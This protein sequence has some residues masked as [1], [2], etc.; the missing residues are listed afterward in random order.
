MKSLMRSR[1]VHPLQFPCACQELLFT[2]PSPPLF[3]SL[4]WNA[5]LVALVDTAALLDLSALL[6][7]VF[8]ATPEL[9]ISAAPV[10]SAAL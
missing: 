7:L 10:P 8:A 3:S 5:F 4:S 1:A 9:P 6:T 2:N